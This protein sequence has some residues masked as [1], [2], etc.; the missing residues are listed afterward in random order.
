MPGISAVVIAKNEE[1]H[2]AA[3]LESLS[4]ADELLVV[5]SFSSDRTPLISRRFTDK[6][7]QRPFDSFPKHRNTALTLASGEWVFF[8][9][10][11]E[12]VTPALAEEIKDTVVRGEKDGYWVPRRN[13]I[14]GK[15]MRH[16]GWYPD[17]Q[18]RLFRRD[19]GRYDERREVHEVVI[20]EGEAGYLKNSIMHYN[21]ERFGQ[22]FA[23]QKRYSDYEAR[24]LFA[25]G[26]RPK[27][28]NFVLQP[29]R[30]FVRRYV[31]GKGYL[32]G[33]H[34]LFLSLVMAWYNLVVYAKLARMG[35]K[36]LRLRR[37]QPQED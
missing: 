18:L 34:G 14:L 19:K 27:P 10:A 21:Y 12:R 3:C 20:L 6:V 25:A 8:L 29:L 15:W 7:F 13:I 17:Y 35:S 26:V 9:D 30:E 28:R 4:W 32:D 16:T 11:D 2:I 36:A 22:L 31:T 23:R 37:S 24:T 1:R 33:F 5:D